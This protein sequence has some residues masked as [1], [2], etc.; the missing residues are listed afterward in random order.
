MQR[1][2][3]CWLGLL[4]RH[5]RPYRPKNRAILEKIAF[6]LQNVAGSWV[7]GG[8][9]NCTP[10]ELRA[11][12]WLSLIGAEVQAPKDPTC[13]GKCHDYFVVKK[14][15][16]GAVFAVH[17]IA[18]GISHPH[19]PVRLYVRAAPRAMKVRTLVTPGSFQAA[20]PF[21]PVTSQ[22]QEEAQKAKSIGRKKDGQMCDIQSEA[23]EL[24]DLMERQLIGVAGLGGQQAINHS[25]RSEGPK[26][27]LKCPMQ[28]AK[29]TKKTTPALRAWKATWKWLG[30]LLLY[31]A[32]SV[33]AD[34]IIRRIMTHDH[35]LGKSVD[36]EEF[37]KWRRTLS[38]TML[39]HQLWTHMLRKTAGEMV[40]SLETEIM[41]K[42]KLAW[43]TWLSEGPAKGLSR[44]A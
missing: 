20:M 37:G 15:L 41:T 39:R 40:V 27:M 5:S 1:R 6:I 36:D 33:E 43:E 13:N 7:L 2:H 16:C 14:D 18:D 11:T 35:E 9:W 23:R 29:G 34:K 17:T 26:V 38:A 31:K 10:D 12:G 8:D 19:S 28:V 30:T 24:V 21:G 3:P 4:V 25:G 22:Q 32:L 42:N 44:Q